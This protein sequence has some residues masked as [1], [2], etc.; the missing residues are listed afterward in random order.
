MPAMLRQETLTALQPPPLVRQDTL[1]GAD[2]DATPRKDAGDATPRK[3]AEDDAT[4]RKE[5]DDTVT[6]PT[7]FSVSNPFAGVVLPGEVS[8]K[9]LL[10]LCKVIITC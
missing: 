10:L 4:P 6:S 8:Q 9:M 1:T 5:E 2:P 3:D 7:A